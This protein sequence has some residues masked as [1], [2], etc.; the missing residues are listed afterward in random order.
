MTRIQT[1]KIL[2]LR[3]NLVQNKGTVVAVNRKLGTVSGTGDYVSPSNEIFVH[4]YSG[5][6][7]SITLLG[8]DSVR[9]GHEVSIICAVDQ[10]KFNAAYE[11]EQAEE[12]VPHY[13]VY[14]KNYT[15]SSRKWIKPSSDALFSFGNILLRKIRFKMVSFSAAMM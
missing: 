8:C 12:T 7:V 9:T 11:S 1:V 14:F 4:T 10:V 2:G 13:P 6:E 5:K 3:V 15:M